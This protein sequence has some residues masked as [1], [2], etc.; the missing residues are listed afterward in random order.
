M[1]TRISI[2]RTKVHMVFTR[3]PS[4]EGRTAKQWL[5][6]LGWLI[7]SKLDKLGKVGRLELVIFRWLIE[8]KLDKLG[9]L[10]R[11]IYL[12]RFRTRYL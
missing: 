12:Y 8:S 11:F 4:R 9:K 5:R 2:L 10:D 3:P 7:R 6:E 1:S